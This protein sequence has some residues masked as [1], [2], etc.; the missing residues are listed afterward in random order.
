MKGKFILLGLI[1]FSLLLSGCG[2]DNI[3]STDTQNIF[4][5]S[6]W[7]P[8]A[9]REM[10]NMNLSAA[11]DFLEAL[12]ATIEQKDINSLRSL[13]APTLLSAFLTDSDLEM[14]CSFIEGDII[15][16]K[17]VAAHGTESK[18]DGKSSAFIMISCDVETTISTYRIAIK[19]CISDTLD[20][21]NIGIN[22]LY[23]TKTENTDMQFAYWGN[24]EW[25][26]G[27]VIDSH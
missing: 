14:L 18:Q 17:R 27:I 11:D 23:I 20:E 19:S 9:F 7:N 15:S 25:L 22:S 6:E 5:T 8:D 3:S 24:N 13:F 16:V 21:N 2:E 4:I 10:R 12:S 26:V 1:I